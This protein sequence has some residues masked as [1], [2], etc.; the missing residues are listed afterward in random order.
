MIRR[1]TP[2]DHPDI[3]SIAGKVYGELGDY[4][5]ILPSWLVHPCIEVYVDVC[6]D[7][8]AAAPAEPMRAFLLLGYFEPL[9]C[10]EP[11]LL[12]DLLAIAVVSGHRQQGTGR[13]LVREAI[14]LA[15]RAAQGFARADI[16]LTVSES[17]PVA[18]RLF[19]S[20]GFEILDPNHGAYHRGQRAIRMHRSLE[21]V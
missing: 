2:N 19:S 8:D 14:R 16:R 13:L 12:V 17:N 1:A 7:Q 9:T 11:Q 6:A 5:A 4:G 18:R 3:T 10:S 21:I 20:E 15:S